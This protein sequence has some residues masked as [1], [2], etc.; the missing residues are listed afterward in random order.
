[1]VMAVILGQAASLD[2]LTWSQGLATS[3][4]IPVCPTPSLNSC[5]SYCECL[6]VWPTLAVPAALL[7]SICNWTSCPTRLLASL[8]PGFPVSL[9]SKV[10]LSM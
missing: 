6:L 5:K 3:V 10:T 8:I 4:P 7:T 1:M 9:C 2:I